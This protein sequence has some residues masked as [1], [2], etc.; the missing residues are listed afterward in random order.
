MALQSCASMF[1]LFPFA[2]GDLNHTQ[3]RGLKCTC[4]IQPEF[5][6]WCPKRFNDTSVFLVGLIESVDVDGDSIWVPDLLVQRKSKNTSISVT[7]SE[8]HT[9][10]TSTIGEAEGVALPNPTLNPVARP[11]TM[12]S[13]RM[14]LEDLALEDT[15][16]QEDLTKGAFEP[17]L[18]CDPQPSQYIPQEDCGCYQEENGP[19]YNLS[20]SEPILDLFPLTR[21]V[22]WTTSYPN[23]K[24][25]MDTLQTPYRT[26]SCKQSFSQDLRL[27]SGAEVKLL[28]PLQIAF[29]PKLHFNASIP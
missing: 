18:P 23:Q 17:P 4:K 28:K 3:S 14:V 10:T 7:E 1:N 27:Y 5:K 16:L 25:S 26:E 6:R 29:A 13:T 20:V 2:D 19:L 12:E 9:L 21:N 24:V 11:P 22:Q 15:D 8:S